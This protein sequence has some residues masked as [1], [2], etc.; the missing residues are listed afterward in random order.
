M[1]HDEI[2]NFKELSSYIALKEGKKKE[3]SIGNVREVLSILSEM[4]ADNPYIVSILIKNGLRLKSL[5]KKLL[6]VLKK[7]SKRNTSHN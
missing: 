6:N 5:K 4:C 2:K 3:V 1:K 7:K